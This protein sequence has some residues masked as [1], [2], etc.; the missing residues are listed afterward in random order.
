MAALTLTLARTASVQ[1]TAWF[2]CV[3]MLML[4][5]SSTKVVA[6][7]QQDNAQKPWRKANFSTR[8]E[9]LCA[10]CHGKNL[11]GAA[12]GP[13]L[14]D[15]DLRYGDSLEA[16]RKSIASGQADSGMPAWSKILTSEQINN[17]ALYVLEQRAGMTYLDFNVDQALVIPQQEISSQRH[18]FRLQT[19]TSDI[20]PLPASIAP[21]P[22]GRVLL[23]EKL[24]GLSIVLKD[25]KQSAL[26]I[27]TPA[28]YDDKSVPDV[29]LYYGVGW[30]LDVAIDPDY[31][32]QDWVYLHYG[33]RCS[34][35]NAKSRET[36]QAVSLNKL[37]RGRIREGK[38]IDEQVLWQGDKV[39]YGLLSD[40][41]AGGRIAFDDKGHLFFSVGLKGNDN[42]RGVQ[43]VG[44]PWG[45]LHRINNDGS[46]PEDN[47]FSGRSNALSSV[48]S[49]GH[50][51]PQG[52]E[53][54]YRT[55]QLWSTEMG[56]RGG[57]EINRIVAGRNYGWPLYSLGV[58]Y[59]GTTVDYGTKLG[60]KWQLADIEQPLVDLTPSPAISSFI[61]YEGSAFPNWQGDMI[62]G[63]LKTSTLYRM[64]FEG[65]KLIEREVLLKGLA[66]IRDIEV[67]ANGEIYLLL[68]HESG[69]KI[70]RMLPVDK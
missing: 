15:G 31:P 51:N 25:G 10:V 9:E 55:G 40:S 8:Y 30:M 38:W 35:C 63:S 3:L 56:P 52:L 13:S 68:E 48:W 19:L 7:E 37:V 22:D 1:H 70:V 66:R 62:V 60:I 49:Y 46:V 24:R 69:G 33:D 65:K 67:A 57:D 61:F 45:K 23:L 54:N 53:Y 20:D 41:A 6:D 17:L 21:L 42:Y 4:M 26:I 64:R 43:D 12:Q 50:R 11:Q 2:S 5:T 16:I 29:G 44:N 39:F 47:P 18:R 14:I 59:D 28:V 34:H 58:N 36:G 27:N 32:N